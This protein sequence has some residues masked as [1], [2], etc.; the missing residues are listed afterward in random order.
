[1]T[2]ID[3]RGQRLRR[4]FYLAAVLLVVPAG[5]RADIV[6]MSLGFTYYEPLFAV[7]LEMKSSEPI[8]A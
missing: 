3:P 6:N 5:A 2:R 7:F 1:M 4:V 8:L